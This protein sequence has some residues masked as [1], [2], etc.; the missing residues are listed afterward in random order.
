VRSLDNSYPG[1]AEFC[2]L[3]QQKKE[4][5][6]TISIMI[7]IMAY[8][9]I[10]IMP[11]FAMAA[12]GYGL[13]GMTGLVLIVCLTHKPENISGYISLLFPF[14][15]LASMQ[16]AFNFFFGG[17]TD[18][19]Y[20]YFYQLLLPYVVIISAFWIVSESEKIKKILFYGI[21]AM[22]IITMITTSVGLVVYEGAS[23]Y[24]AT[25]NSSDAEFITYMWQNIGGYDFIYNLVLILPM[26]IGLYKQK[27]IKIYI[28]IPILLFTIVM[29]LRAEYATALVIF[30]A[31]IVLLFLKKKLSMKF[32][33]IYLLVFILLFSVFKSSIATG[34]D[35]LS[36]T[37]DS[38]NLSERFSSMASELRGEDA[39]EDTDLYA[40]EKLY[41]ASWQ[42]FLKS[43][44]GGGF[45]NKNLRIGGHSFFLDFLATYG[46]LGSLLLF[47]CY[48]KIYKVFYEPFK[49]EDYFG[50]MIWSF[51][52][53]LF[54]SAVNTGMW[55]MS[56]TLLVPI[57]AW[58]IKI[59]KSERGELIDE[60][61]ENESTLGN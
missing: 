52:L 25:A 31:S 49:D 60:E 44:I 19:L 22:L 20:L 7:I 58:Y 15:A 42:S 14:L 16:F 3:Q 6:I 1:Y 40:R 8:L 12:G 9:A 55:T 38:K 61:S 11:I 2:R 47:Y 46:I 32:V 54:L 26:V 10:N 50:Y 29:L 56:L 17:V 30:V 4:K 24:L 41:E 36:K 35:S 13:L 59:K 28:L 45:F 48:Y 18:G 33:I 43:P 51:I 23:R 21:S 57:T 27:C 5:R 53:A 39:D 34:L 37:V